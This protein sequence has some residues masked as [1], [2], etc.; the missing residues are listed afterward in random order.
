MHKDTTSHEWDVQ[1]RFV[2]EKR[3]A[4][5]TIAGTPRTRIACDSQEMFQG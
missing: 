5:D 2:A 1:D 4:N 3:G